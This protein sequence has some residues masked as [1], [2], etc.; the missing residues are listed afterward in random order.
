MVLPLPNPL[1]SPFLSPS[2]PCLPLTLTLASPLVGASV[3]HCGMKAFL[4]EVD[5][6]RRTD[7]L[8]L[9]ALG[10]LRAGAYSSQDLGQAGLF[11]RGWWLQ[12][13]VL[14]PPPTS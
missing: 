6:A 9:L 5:T 4:R 13:G 12:L 1:R 3:S 2:L 7:A 14:W 10:D 11:G 8:P